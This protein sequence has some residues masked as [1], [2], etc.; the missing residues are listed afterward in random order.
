MTINALQTNRF[1]AVT[2]IQS[3]HRSHPSS[4]ITI[5]NPAKLPKV[6][7][8]Q[9]VVMIAKALS[10]FYL[11]LSSELRF[12]VLHPLDKRHIP[13]G[14]LPHKIHVRVVDHDMEMLDGVDRFQGLP[15]LEPNNLGLPHRTSAYRITQVMSETLA[16]HL[17]TGY[18]RAE[19]PPH[20]LLDLLPR[21]RGEI[22]G[23]GVVLELKFDPDNQVNDVRFDAIRPVVI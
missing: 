5:R 4:R 6:K 20:I 12:A 21:F 14:E 15:V 1:R 13:M 7:I 9:M 10:S 11:H 18:P 19:C 16:T 23:C 3:K 17:F 22:V 8:W 2:P